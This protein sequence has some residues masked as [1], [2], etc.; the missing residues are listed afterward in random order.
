MEK[1]NI[2]CVDDQRTVLSSLMTDLESFEQYYTI[3]ECESADEAWE[4]LDEMDSKGELIGLIISDHVM[5]GKTGVDFLIEV[6]DDGRFDGTKKMLL[7]GLATHQDTIT[8]INKANIDQYLEK[9]Y[10]PE[11]LHDAVK[12]LTTA[13]LFEQGIPYQDFTEVLDQQTLLDKMRQS[14]F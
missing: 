2:I 1:I 5:P 10:K 14:S 11:A 12:K 3:E 7:T 8:A 4:L 13:F 9:P 6:N